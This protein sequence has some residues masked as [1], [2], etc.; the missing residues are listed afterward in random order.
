M[1]PQMVRMLGSSGCAIVSAAMIRAIATTPIPATIQLAAPAQPNGAS[2]PGRTKMP[3]PI[4]PPTTI[5]VAVQ[6]RKAAP[7]PPWHIPPLG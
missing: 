7:A 3:A 2:A 6:I 1:S 4:M 5:A